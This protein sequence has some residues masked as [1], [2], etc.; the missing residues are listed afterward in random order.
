MARLSSTDLYGTKL[1][2]RYR[3]TAS[4]PTVEKL[5]SPSVLLPLSNCM[6]LFMESIG[7]YYFIFESIIFLEKNLFF[8]CCLTYDSSCFIHDSTI[9]NR[10]LTKL[11]IE[12][13]RAPLAVLVSDI[14]PE[15]AIL[16]LFLEINFFIFS[17]KYWRYNTDV[18]ICSNKI[19]L[20]TAIYLVNFDIH[21]GFVG[22]PM[23]GKLAI[24]LRSEELSQTC[25]G[26]VSRFQK[27]SKLPTRE[28]DYMPILSRRIRRLFKVPDWRWPLS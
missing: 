4:F 25:K 16:E 3:Q 8:F 17:C 20:E 27:E 12:T 5:F 2:Y 10:I 15:Q 21:F 24:R 28:L 1:L 9:W 7:I 13:T 19:C 6:F 11:L 23:D 26:R 18:K 22:I 14:I